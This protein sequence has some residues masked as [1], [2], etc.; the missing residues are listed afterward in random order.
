MTS[1]PARWNCACP[2]GTFETWSH[3]L[4]MRLRGPSACW[5]WTSS[6]RSRTLGSTTTYS[7][8]A[9]YD[10]PGIRHVSGPG[11]RGELERVRT[12]SVGG[13]SL[14]T[15]ADDKLPVP[16]AGAALIEAC[17]QHDQRSDRQSGPDLG[18]RADWAVAAHR[19]QALSRM[20]QLRIAANWTDPADQVRCVAWARDTAAA[21]E[22]HSRGA[23]S[24]ANPTRT[25]PTCR[26]RSATALSGLAH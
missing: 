20:T 15:T 25:V 13:V 5:A 8:S 11:C 2:G 21:L 18:R 7:H 14:L 23:T 22:P 4:V 6:P 1:S 17:S 16:L 9:H 10:A 24:I 3:M 12:E 26:L 19:P